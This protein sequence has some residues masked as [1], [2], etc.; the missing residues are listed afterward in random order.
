MEES[1]E[2]DLPSMDKVRADHAC[3]SEPASHAHFRRT[4]MLEME[5][6]TKLKGS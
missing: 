5:K 3:R 1:K 6:N 4:R 2:K